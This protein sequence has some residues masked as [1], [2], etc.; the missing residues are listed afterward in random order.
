MPASQRDF[1]PQ[2]TNL[3]SDFDSGPWTR[4]KYNMLI[5]RA[6]VILILCLMAASAYADGWMFANGR[7]PEGKVT[8]LELTKSQKIFLDLVRHCRNNKKTPFVFRLSHEQS[9][10][11]KREAGFSPTRFAVFES[12][13]GDVGVDIEVN[14]INRFNEAEFEIPHKL[15][16]HDHEARDWEIHT[17]GWLPNP[18]ENANP[19]EIKSGACP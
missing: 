14:V 11:L 3:K 2:A 4:K 5:M 16:T 10:V 8:V 1:V 12:Y 18:L 15:L 6:G 19:D 13:R 7:F 17:I 9:T